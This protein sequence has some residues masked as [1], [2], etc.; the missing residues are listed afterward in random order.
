MDAAYLS[1][2][3]IAYQV[4]PE[5]RQIKVAWELRALMT[6]V[7]VIL[8][9]VLLRTRYFRRDTPPST[10][11]V[12]IVRVG[13]GGLAAAGLWIIVDLMRGEAFIA[14]LWDVLPPEHENE[15]NGLIL[16]S[17]GLIAWSI[18]LSECFRVFTCGGPQTESKALSADGK[19]E[20]GPKEETAIPAVRSDDQ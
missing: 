7:G 1:P 11:G 13:L 9:Y 20:L 2:F 15:L 17:A 6:A 12:A 19:L 10:W 16:V 5:L 18:V 3:A 8:A 14:S 4:L